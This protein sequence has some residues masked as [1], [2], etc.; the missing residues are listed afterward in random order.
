MADMGCT[1]SSMAEARTSVIPKPGKDQSHC[2]SYRPIALLNIDAK[3]YSAILAHRLWDLMPAIIHPDQSGFI[4]GRQTHDNLRRV[5]HL[6]KKASRMRLPA[7]LVGLDAEKAFDRVDWN[8]MFRTLVAF[9]FAPR[10]LTM[11]RANYSAPCSRVI[12]NGHRSA[13]FAHT[14]GTR[15]GC[16]LSPLLFALSIEPLAIALREHELIQGLPFSV[17]IVPLFLYATEY[18]NQNGSEVVKHLPEAQAFPDIFSF[19][20]V[21]SH[22]NSTYILANSSFTDDGNSTDIDITYATEPTEVPKNN[23]ISGHNFLKDEN[24]RVGLLLA[25]KALMQLLMSPFVGPLTNRIGHHIPMFAGFVIMFLSTLM[26]AFS[27]TYTLLFL[28]RMLQGIGSSFSSVAGLG[29]LASVYTDDS[30]RGKAM[31]IALG[32]VALG[33]LVGAPFGSVMYSFVG[34]SSPFL[35]LALLA[36]LDGALQFCILSPSKMSPES[37][38]GAAL[39]TLLRDPYILAAAGAICFANMGMAM[40]EPTLPIRML[41][42]MCSSDW[43]L[44][45]ALVPASISYL[46]CTSLFG[47][48][49]NKMGRWLCSMIG[50]VIIGI[51]L[52][53]VP[54]ANN[55][56]GL[57]APSGGLGFGIGMVEFSMIPIMGHLVDL[58]HTSVYGS[59][60]AIA[61]V[62]ICMGFAIGPST[63][64]AIVKAI[65]FPWLMVIIGVIN[66]AYA[67]ICVCLRSPPA[68]EDKMAILNSECPMDTKCYM[69]QKSFREHPLSDSSN[70]EEARE[71]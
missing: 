60:Y 46:I 28:A 9:G 64:G 15:Q 22:D 65:G 40:L 16:P 49:A 63:G 58:R 37:A 59:V 25:S 17:P 7:V 45:L 6:I 4:K 32:G 1:T 24:T 61:D 14:R 29:M 3:L 71:E 52:L 18:E 11:I 30:E 57:I 12:V 68:K 34:K 66:I 13:G 21:L 70:E 62:A 35:V 53:C 8:F 41:Q 47:V 19:T 42:T 36:L 26:F 38:K 51:S 55:I 23:C 27:G 54:F 10:F 69:T 48:M 67:P 31:G 5:I 56:Y 50:M 33:I 43:E 44:G 2:S 20:S 39:F